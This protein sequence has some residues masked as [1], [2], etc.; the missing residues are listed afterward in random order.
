MDKKV[1]LDINSY[2]LILNFITDD[3]DSETYLV[4]SMGPNF[5][6]QLAH[7]SNKI[8]DLQIENLRVIYYIYDKPHGITNEEIKKIKYEYYLKWCKYFKFNSVDKN[9][10][11]KYVKK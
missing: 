1:H 10:F 11:L 5:I 7:I 6:D 2:K 4:K 8:T 3:F 9:N